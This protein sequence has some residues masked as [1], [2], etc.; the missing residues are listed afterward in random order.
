MQ[1]V[2]CDTQCYTCS[3]YS[4]SC[5][6]CNSGFTLS[7]F[8]CVSDLRMTFWMVLDATPSNFSANYYSAFVN[9]VAKLADVTTGNVT[10]N[11]ISQYTSSRLLETSSSRLLA[12]TGTNVTGAVS[13]YPALSG[14]SG[15]DIY[16]NMNS[17]SSKSS[18]VGLPVTSA[19]ST[20]VGGTIETLTHL[21]LALILG[22]CIP[23]GILLIVAVAVFCYCR[24]KKSSTVIE[25]RIK[26]DGL[27]V[28]ET[29]EL[30]NDAT[31]RRM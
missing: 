29:F 1:C 2:A 14:T 8:H 25:K 15:Y 17:L 23:V 22:I 11:G 7:G 31:A 3:G 30:S 28:R 6:S 19:K 16:S 20:L 26:E 21:N 4:S 27:S 13:I 9:A 10:V 12:A 5:T 24:S 18:F